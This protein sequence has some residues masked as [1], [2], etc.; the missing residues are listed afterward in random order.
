MVPIKATSTY[1][2]GPQMAAM[3]FNAR[4]E[5]PD[6]LTADHVVALNMKIFRKVARLSMKRVGEQLS[7]YTG[8]TYTPQSMSYWENSAGRASA[9]PCT[10]QELYGLSRILSV[11]VATLVTVPE[12]DRWL[13]TPIRG[14]DD[15]SARMLYAQFTN[16]PNVAKAFLDNS[17]MLVAAAQINTWT[18]KQASDELGVS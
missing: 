2:K 5:P 7:R 3:K 11:P 9:R 16:D 15:S 1:T 17:G 6:V 10:T 14:V 8:Q 12:D 13:N 4:V 18:L